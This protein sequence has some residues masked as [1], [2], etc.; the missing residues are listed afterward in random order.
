[1]RRPF[2]AAALGGLLLCLLSAGTFYALPGW[3]GLFFDGLLAVLLR[4]DAVHLGLEPHLQ[5]SRASQRKDLRPLAAQ[6]RVMEA[7]LDR[8]FTVEDGRLFL[9]STPPVQLGD[10]CLWQGVYAAEAALRWSQA[11]TPR[12]LRRARRALEGL[13]LLMTHGWPI[14]RSVYP[15]GLAAESP[16]PWYSRDGRWQ[17]KEDASIDSASGWIFG[18]A[19]LRELVPP[20][21][22]KADAGLLRFSRRLRGAGYLLRNSDGS[23]TRYCRMGGAVFNSPPG[24]LV[25][26][27]ALKAAARANPAGPWA[28]DHQDLVAK[29]QDRWGAYGSGPLLWNNKT[30]NHNIAFLALAAALLTED[31]PERKAV[32]ARGLVRLEHVTQNMGNSFWLYLGHWVLAR[33]GMTAPAR[34]GVVAEF[35][36][37][38]TAHFRAA[39]V[40]MLEWDYPACKVLRET[41]NSQRS[42]LNTRPWP[43]SGLRVLS[44][45][46]P[47]WQRPPADFI[48]QRSAHS[49]DDWLGYRR[50]PPQRFS[51]LDFLVAYRLGLAA[52]GL[53]PGR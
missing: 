36:A 14:A 8:L 9:I 29:G 25:T 20:L 48:W 50:E 19:M 30:T 5:L 2:R 33:S 40:A 23:P 7:D 46:L 15:A 35:L 52:G 18:A 38:R 11:P 32:Y 28:A 16:G 17:W 27:A 12:N 51:P 47:L 24:V 26:L 1:M 22:P 41:V 37:D 45:P 10:V 44:Q 39:Q 21:R 43:F 49:L 53:A 42:D 4:W 34:D 6:A 3:R 31:S 13:E